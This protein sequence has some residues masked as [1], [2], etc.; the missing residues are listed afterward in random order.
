MPSQFMVD[1]EG[2][3]LSNIERELLAH[4]NVGAVILFTRNFINPEQLA[5]LIAEIRSTNPALFIAVD[6]EG[7]N[8]Q[9]FQRQGFSSIPA[10]RSYGKVYDLHQEAGLAHAQEYGKIMAQELLA[11]DIDLSLAPVL[12]LE[13]NSRVIAGLDRAFHAAADAVAKLAAAF[14]QG[15]NDAGMPAVGKHF[16]GHGSIVSDSHITMPTSPAPLEELEA[17]DLKPFS[18]LINKSLLTAV[19]PAHVTYE[20]IDENNPAGF[21]KIW[22]HDILRTKLGFKGLVL[23]DCLSMKGA[24]IGNLK[25]RA[26]HAL[27]AGCDMLIVCHQPRKLLLE[28]I[29]SPSIEQTPESAARITAFKKQMIRFSKGHISP[30]SLYGKKSADEIQVIAG[31]NDEFNKTVE[32]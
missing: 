25:T 28:L 12:D 11:H 3:E 17:N 31:P 15:M 18:E 9:R 10:A 26:E 1:I 19:M 29:Q 16:P 5:Q 22:L 7:G 21:S 4:P 30:Y 14:I 13:G 23:S 8:V 27:N 24:D 2:T 6:H 20:A 32:I